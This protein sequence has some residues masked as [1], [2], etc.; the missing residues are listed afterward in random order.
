M[1]AAL[2]IL[3]RSWCNVWCLSVEQ[4]APVLG[5]RERPCRRGGA[6]EAARSLTLGGPRE[7]WVRGGEG[8]ELNAT[9]VSPQ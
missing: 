8:L 2:L 5:D 4:D 9:A 6:A 1:T 7:A 3:T